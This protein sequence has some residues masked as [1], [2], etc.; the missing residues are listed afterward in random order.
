MSDSLTIKQARNLRD[1][2]QEVVAEKVGVTLPTWRR[3]ENYESSIPARVFMNFC[4][5]VEMMPDSIELKK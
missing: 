1:L 5:F 2:T 3:Y 4:L